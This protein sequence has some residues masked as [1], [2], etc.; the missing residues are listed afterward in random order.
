MKPTHAPQRAARMNV[1]FGSATK[2][3]T[4]II[5]MELIADT[6]HASPS[7]PSMRLTAFVHPTIHS[8]VSGMASEPMGIVPISDMKLGFET[9]VKIMPQRIATSAAMICMDSFIH[10]RRL[11]MSSTAPITAMM[12]APSLSLIHI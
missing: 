7:S 5:V 1:V 9:A 6:P 8:T 3:E 2:S 10:G 4:I 12:S 11:T